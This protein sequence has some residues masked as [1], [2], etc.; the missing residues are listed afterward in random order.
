MGYL[1]RRSLEEEDRSGERGKSD[2]GNITRMVSGLYNVAEWKGDYHI[3]R[4]SHKQLCRKP[5]ACVGCTIHIN[6]P[7]CMRQSHIIAL[8][9]SSRS[10]G[11]RYQVHIP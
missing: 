10:C 3:G 2:L 1:N 9:V 8:G 11:D 7:L 6:E 4:V 5:H